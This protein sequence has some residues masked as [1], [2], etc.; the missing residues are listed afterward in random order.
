MGRHTRNRGARPYLTNYRI[1][2]LEDAVR[3][4]KNG[5]S[6]GKA[7]LSWH[8]PKSTLY[9]KVRGLQPKKPGGQ[10]HLSVDC[11]NALL[12]IINDLTDWKYPL[13]GYDI[14]VMVK[15]YLDKRGV[16]SSKFK[17]NFPGR[18]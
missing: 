14:R 9:R 3:N 10:L 15:H 11:E 5:Q 1:T 17:N 12:E 8:I 16:E 2:D 13:C 4:V 18:D 6:L 7:A